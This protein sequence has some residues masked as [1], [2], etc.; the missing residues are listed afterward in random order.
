MVDPTCSV[1]LIFSKSKNFEIIQEPRANQMALVVSTSK[2]RGA[3][4]DYVCH[5]IWGLSCAQDKQIYLR[6]RY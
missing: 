2:V 1:I 3:I 4:I 6:P 5:S